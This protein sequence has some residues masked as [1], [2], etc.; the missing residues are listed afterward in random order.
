MKVTLAPITK[1]TLRPKQF[2]KQF[3]IDR[4]FVATGH[5]FKYNNAKEQIND[6]SSGQIN[7]LSEIYNKSMHFLKF[8]GSD[9]FNE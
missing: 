1:Q 3:R 7:V 4:Y 9:Y 2:L 5:L 8:V 6:S